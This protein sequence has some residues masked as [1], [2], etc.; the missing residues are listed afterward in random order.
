MNETTDPIVRVSFEIQPFARR[1]VGC[2]EREVAFV[3]VEDEMTARAGFGE[4]APLA[5]L[6][7]ESLSDAMSDLED[8]LDGTREISALAPSSAFAVS[9]ALATSEGFGGR[10]VP[11]ARVAAFFA[12][13]ADELDDNEIARLASASVIK[14]KIG[15]AAVTD[16]RRL[17]EHALASFP[18]ARFRLDGN[19]ALSLDDCVSLLRGLDVARFEYLEEPLVDPSQ[20]STLANSTGIA[21]ALDESVVDRSPGARAL[22]A[23]L[24]RDGVV[25]AWVLRMS[26][27]GALDDVYAIAADAAEHQ[28]DVVLSTAYESSYT[29][30]LAVHVAAAIPNARRAHGLGT[31]HLLVTDSC[32]PAL[33][34]DGKLAGD[35]LP[36]PLAEAWE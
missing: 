31:A 4:C 14:L 16:E 11:A 1:F 22:R 21:I 25:S 29:L 2:A 26:A 6:H 5:G 27:I 13:T 28:A 34:R 36:I 33:V 23:Q 35:P 18:S 8:F 9:C 7:G 3:R 10:A 20:L 19:R 15:R 32:A 17:L 30:R 12:G 24:A